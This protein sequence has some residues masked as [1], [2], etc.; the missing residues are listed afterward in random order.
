MKRLQVVAHLDLP[1]DLVDDL[2][3]GS[4]SLQAMIDNDTNLNE[5][6]QESYRSVVISFSHV[7]EGDE[8]REKTD[9]RTLRNLANRLWSQYPQ[10]S[11]GFRGPLGYEYI[12]VRLGRLS[13]DVRIYATDSDEEIVEKLKDQVR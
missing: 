10:C 1:D 7:K 11:I 9:L 5:L 3:A 4:T 13:D 2:V 6:V 8:T 12:D